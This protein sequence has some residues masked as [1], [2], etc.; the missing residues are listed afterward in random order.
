MDAPAND[1]RNRLPCVYVRNTDEGYKVWVGTTLPPSEVYPEKGGYLPLPAQP[2]G[3]WSEPPKDC[4][5][6]PTETDALLEAFKLSD[7][8]L[9]NCYGVIYDG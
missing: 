8:M 5:V 6:Y 1:A 7:A 4:P 3:Q 2:T 9:P